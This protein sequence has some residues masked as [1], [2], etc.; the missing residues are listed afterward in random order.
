MNILTIGTE[1]S[2]CMKLHGCGIKCADLFED[3]MKEKFSD[4]INKIVSLRG[5]DCTSEKISD[6][7]ESITKNEGK[8][9]I[10]YSGHGNHLFMDLNYIEYWDT[11]NGIIDQIKIAKM[12][13]KISEDSR[14][15]FF[16]E[17]CSSEHLINKIVMKK[18]YLSIGACHDE[19]DAIITSDGGLFTMALIETI[20]E[21]SDDCKIIDFVNILN[22]KRVE[23]ES[24]S[25]R[26]SHEK[27]FDEKMWL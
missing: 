22:D 24:F 14:V 11:P 20:R 6:E 19:E 27:L 21:S 25:I 23:V 15:L 17:S 9:I 12:L 4:K 2:G 26:L 3:V 13:N 10:F 1:Y 8:I 7:I 5:F 18:H 16:S